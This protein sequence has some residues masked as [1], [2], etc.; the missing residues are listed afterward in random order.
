MI[1][2]HISELYKEDIE[3]GLKLLPKLTADHIF[4]NSYSVMKVK[5]ATQ[6]LSFSVGKVL[7]SF[8]YPEAKGTSEFCLKFD[9]FFDCFNVRNTKE[10]LLKRKDF[11]KPYTEVDDFRFAWLDIFIQYL[12]NWK[13][14]IMEREGA[15]SQADRKLCSFHIKHTKV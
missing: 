1:W 7:D 5:L 8:G 14:S 10:H 15:F 6:I 11:L 2:R 13:K 3:C 12:E 9:S 4:L